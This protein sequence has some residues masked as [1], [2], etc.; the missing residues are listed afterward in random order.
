MADNRMKAVYKAAAD[1][2]SRPRYI[3]DLVHQLAEPLKRGDSIDVPAFSALTQKADGAT[4]AAPDAVSMSALSVLADLHPAIVAAMPQLS[5]EQLMEGGWASALVSE[6]LKQ[7]R[8]GM[9]DALVQYLLKSITGTS[10]TYHENIGGVMLTTEHILAARAKI[11]SGGGGG[12]L[13]LFVNPMGFGAMQRLSG[14]QPSGHTPPGAEFYGVPLLGSVYGIPIY[15]SQAIQP[16]TVTPS[17]TSVTSNVA[18]ATVA[19]GHGFLAGQRIKTTGATTDATNATISSVTATT[20]VYPLTASN[21]ALAAPGV[22]ECLTHENLLIDL[23]VGVYV[24]Q[25]KAPGFRIVQ[26]A[27]STN[28]V[29]Q[30]SSIW[31]RTGRAGRV[32]AIGTNAASI[33]TS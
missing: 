19:A 6:G 16:K 3:V 8:N 1:L 25:Q 15:E 23:D 31:G 18:T 12:P 22:I 4:R 2:N 33:L 30:V 11:R 28:D 24:A 27:E 20:I 21:G 26:D 9:D 13:A 10:T 14:F 5:Q 29:L 32:I 7:L 17:E